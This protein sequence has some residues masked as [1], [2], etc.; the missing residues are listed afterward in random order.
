MLAR[1]SFLARP[2]ATTLAILAACQPDGAAA[3]AAQRVVATIE[4][5]ASSAFIMAGDT[6][7][8]TAIARDARGAI[9][10]GAALTW[11]SSDEGVLAV[12]DGRAVGINQGSARLKASAGTATAEVNVTVKLTVAE[13]RFAYAF[14]HDARATAPYRPMHAFAHNA[15]GG[16]LHV[17]RR[18]T[19]RY[20]VT[21][22][23][24]AK[25]DSSFKEG[26]LV[27]AYGTKGERCHIDGWADAPNHRDLDAAVS[28]F[29]T[30][31]AA[32]DAQF[33]ILLVGAQS[34]PGRHG[35]TALE[36][37]TAGTSSVIPN[38]YSSSGQAVGVDR[39]SAGSY[40]V[41]LRAPRQEFPE[42]YFVS[43]VGDGSELCKVSTWNFGDWARVVCYAPDGA[44]V[45]A[46]FS[47]LMVEGG[48]PGKRFGFAWAN[49]PSAP[50][51]QAYTPAA[52][53]QRSSSGEPAHVTHVATGEYEVEFPGLANGGATAEIVQVSPFGSG[54]TSCQLAGWTEDVQRSL[55]AQVHCWNRATGTREDGQFTVLVLE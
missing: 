28:C 21:F 32:V 48:R 42:N 10:E 16:E 9:V 26:V 55:R 15:T 14:A 41:R 36:S 52:M 49:D 12:H 30:Q 44:R 23:R 35:F 38:S 50:Y 53:Y 5:S 19:G 18:T 22:G 17:A 34:L 54:L 39:P 24:L 6:V 51:G 7:L 8:P 29:D 4:V 45:D 46:R 40:M 33:T 47:L 13:R 37:S 27:T 11:T 2:F 3:P 25:V 43:T 20:T 31:N 1:R